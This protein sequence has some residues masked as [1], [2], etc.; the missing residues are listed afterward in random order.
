MSEI[1]TNKLTGKTAAGNVTIT[2][3]SVTM[4]LQH[5]V[6][7][8]YINYNHGS[9]ITVRDSMNISST[10]D[11]GVGYAT[12]S[13]TNSFDNDDYLGSGIVR[14]PNVAS[15]CNF[16]FPADTDGDQATGS[17]QGYAILHDG[18]N[19]DF[20]HNHMIIHGDLA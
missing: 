4:K 14:T 11:D 10:S 12:H 15:G 5:G 2:D 9:S 16:Q 6:A 13:F 20:T 3:G 8:A 19:T 17:V 18:N 7:K 1:I